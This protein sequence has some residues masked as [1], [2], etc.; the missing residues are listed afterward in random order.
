MRQFEIFSLMI[1]NTQPKFT[2]LINYR[3][4]RNDRKKEKLILKNVK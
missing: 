4:V 1:P 3:V 2:I